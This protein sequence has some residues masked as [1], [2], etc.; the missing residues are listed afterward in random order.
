M[1]IDQE[2]PSWERRVLVS[3]PV[4]ADSV[5]TFAA[6]RGVDFFRS[7]VIAVPNRL[8]TWFDAIIRS[9]D[10]GSAAHSISVSTSCSKSRAAFICWPKKLMRNWCSDSSDDGGIEVMAG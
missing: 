4:E 7:P 2:L 9:A 1:L 5:A 10:H 8:R 6:I 3:L